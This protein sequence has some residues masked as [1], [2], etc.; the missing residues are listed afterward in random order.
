MLAVAAAMLLS[1]APAPAAHARPDEL[2]F[3]LAVVLH[4]CAESQF[5]ADRLAAAIESAFVREPVTAIRGAAPI[6]VWFRAPRC[7][8]TDRRVRVAV[9]IA[10]RGVP[11]EVL[12]VAP[13][14]ETPEARSVHLAREAHAA[15]TRLWPGVMAAAGGNPYVVDMPVAF[16]VNPYRQAVSQRGRHASQAEW[17]PPNPYR[18]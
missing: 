16:D 7:G 6:R 17:M 12:A 13:V 10:D 4:G 15:L 11:L 14:G 8:A 3:E 2:P 9:E 5:G 18:H 1:A